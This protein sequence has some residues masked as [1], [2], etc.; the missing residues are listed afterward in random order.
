[1]LMLRWE[2]LDFLEVLGVAPV[3]GEYGTYY[4]YVIKREACRLEVKVWPLD[5]DIRV[6][7][8]VVDQN[9][10]IFD[11]NLLDCQGARVVS[12]KRGRYIELAP[13]NVFFGRY[14]KDDTP[15]FGFRIQVDPFIQ[16][17]PFSY[18]V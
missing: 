10:P 8:F 1:M 15:A 9:E 5:S 18:D 11:A 2:P 7:L 17:S 3:E 14:E 6:S 13:A 12:D 16:V 4:E